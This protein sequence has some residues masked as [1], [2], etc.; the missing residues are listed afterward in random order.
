MADKYCTKSGSFDDTSVWS[1]VG[2]PVT[3]DSLYFNLSVALQN[4]P[5]MQEN[6][7]CKDLFVTN[8]A[9]AALSMQ[10][11]NSLFIVNE[12]ISVDGILEDS[13]TVIGQ[14]QLNQYD[15]LEVASGG[16]VRNVS[17]N[18]GNLQN[19]GL[20]QGQVLFQLYDPSPE[21]HSIGYIDGS[22]SV[23][24]RSDTGR[25]YRF[26]GNT[27]VT[28]DCTLTTYQT[29]QTNGTSTCHIRT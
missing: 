28:K 16:E 14:W 4:V 2:M 15:P 21:N 5:G 13:R 8:N 11:S 7:R 19:K 26:L 27:T 24:F 22:L 12:T 29:L 10:N 6:F 3:G 20:I 9:H 17:V 23:R 18:L 1:P 25:S